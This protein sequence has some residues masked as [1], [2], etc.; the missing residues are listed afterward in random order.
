MSTAGNLMEREQ[1]RYKKKIYYRNNKAAEPLREGIF[2]FIRQKYGAQHKHKLSLVSDGSFRFISMGRH[3]VSLQIGQEEE[4]V[5]HDRVGEA[6]PP[7]YAFD[8]HVFVQ[9][10]AIRWHQQMKDY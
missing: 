2:V 9:P 8:S 1:K 3:T 4:Q 7:P 6:P 5:S 10:V